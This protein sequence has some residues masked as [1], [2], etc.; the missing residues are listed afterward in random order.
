MDSVKA[1]I[2]GVLINDSAFLALCSAVY[3]KNMTSVSNPIY[4]C[5]T[6]SFEKIMSEANEI[7]ESGYYVIDVWSKKGND[8][9]V[10]IYTRV[11][12]LI[13]KKKNLGGGIIYCKQY[14]A[15][16]DLYEADTK[17][18]HLCCKYKVIVLDSL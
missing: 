6:I 11:K 1:T 18:Y 14:H 16:D 13:N 8:E 7:S 9:L 12:Q 10:S 4:P 2:R 17:T 5:V 15:N 3:P